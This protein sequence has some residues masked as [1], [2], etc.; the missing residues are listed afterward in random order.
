VDADRGE[1]GTAEQRRLWLRQM[2][3]SA[4][5]D[6]ES[7]LYDFL[8]S[9]FGYGDSEALEIGLEYLYNADAQ[10]VRSAAG[11]LRD[12]YA[13]SELIPALRKVEEQR[14]TSTAVEQ[15]LVDVGDKAPGR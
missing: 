13:A 9:I 14:G 10:V 1:A 7:L 6:R 15:R 11:Y 12:Y 2:R 5:T 3:R 4:P 8:P